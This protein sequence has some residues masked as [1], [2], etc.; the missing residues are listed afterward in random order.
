MSEQSKEIGPEARKKASE[1]LAEATENDGEPVEDR[2]VAAN[3]NDSSSNNQKKSK[4]SKL[5]KAL[6]AGSKDGSSKDS[7]NPAS[8]LTPEMV[9]QLLEM[10][11]SLKGEVSGMSK[12]K[13]TETLQKLDVADLLTGMVLSFELLKS[14][15]IADIV[16]Q[17]VSGKNQKDM[18]SYKFW[19]TQPV[20]RFGQ[21]YMQVEA[22]N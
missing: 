22:P 20:P 2:D 9:D 4:R 15:Q 17:S 7:S 1:E 21:F 13:A 3:E 10:N 14:I 11:P 19:Q 8:K 5:K 6:G 12:E 16:I 18:A